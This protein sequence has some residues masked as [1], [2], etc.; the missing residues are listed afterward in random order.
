MD[1]YQD[2]GLSEEVYNW[3]GLPADWWTAIIE[4][5]GVRT[6]RLHYYIHAC[7]ISVCVGRMKGVCMIMCELIYV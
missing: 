6:P 2:P 3:S 7:A 5:G 1:D 4:V